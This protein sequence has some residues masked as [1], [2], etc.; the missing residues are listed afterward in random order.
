MAAV[1]PTPRGPPVTLV[2][3]TEDLLAERAVAGGA[4]PPPARHD[5]ERRGRRDAGRRARRAATWACTPA[6]RCSPSRPVR[7]RARA[8]GP[9]ATTWSTDC[10]AYLVDAGRRRRPGAACTAAGQRARACSTRPRK[11]GAAVIDCPTVKLRTPT[12]PRFVTARVPRRRRR[13]T[14]DAAAA[15]VEAVGR[16]CASWPARCAPADR[17]RP[18]GRALDVDARGRALLR[19]PGRGHRLQGRRRRVRRAA[20]SEALELLR[21]AL[22]AGVD[23]VPIVAVPRRA[24]CAR[25]PRW[26]QRGLERSADVARDARPGALAGRQGPPPAARLDARRAGRGDQGGGRRPT[27]AVKGGGGRPGVRA[28]SGP[29]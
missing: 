5:A 3:G 14:P 18:P 23:P 7:R 6:R 2:T 1:T 10:S 26:R 25:S 17:R 9:P 15:L 29:S 13:S 12:R 8:G 4:S 21:H 22:G 20:P 27:P 28:S 24:A 11:A 16:T 19:R